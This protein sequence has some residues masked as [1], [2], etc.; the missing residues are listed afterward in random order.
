MQLTY[1]VPARVQLN[2]YAMIMTGVQ[3]NSA[4]LHMCNA[5]AHI[6]SGNCTHLG[7][8][9]AAGLATWGARD[10]CD[11]YLRTCDG[12]MTEQPAGRS[13]MGAKMR[14]SSC[15]SRAGLA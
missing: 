15:R 3:H 4:E 8:H 6:Q 1:L 14:A 2:V 11:R 13:S 7:P 12:A 10:L 9:P 5:V